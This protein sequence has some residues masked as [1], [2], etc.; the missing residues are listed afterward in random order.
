[1]AILPLPVATKQR[2]AH[3]TTPGCAGSTRRSREVISLSSPDDHPWTICSLAAVH[4]RRYPR[5]LARHTEIYA[6][7]HLA[8]VFIALSATRMRR[9]LCR[10]EK[11]A[12]P[13]GTGR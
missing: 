10:R 12:R 11:I 13:Q 3:G 9:V 1:M 8:P 7:Q 4:Q 6:G 5:E 2:D